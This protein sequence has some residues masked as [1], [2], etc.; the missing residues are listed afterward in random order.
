MPGWWCTP[1]IQSF[2]SLE[3]RVTLI[4]SPLHSPHLLYGGHNASHRN[5]GRILPLCLG[6]AARMEFGSLLRGEVREGNLAQIRSSAK[7]FGLFCAQVNISDKER[8]SIQRLSSKGPLTRAIYHSAKV[9][10]FPILM[11]FWRRYLSIPSL[12]RWRKLWGCLYLQPLVPLP[13]CK[14]R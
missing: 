3:A 14:C 7:C 4:P 13:C 8:D 11:Y 1:P 9:T 12:P 6:Q 2:H 5:P 10:L